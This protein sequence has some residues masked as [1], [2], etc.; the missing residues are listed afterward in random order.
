MENNFSE[1]AKRSNQEFNTAFHI[2]EDLMNKDCFNFWKA[3]DMNY[4]ERKEY[5][6]D[7]IFEY[8]H[9]GE[10]DLAGV[11]K[12]VDTTDYLYEG[13]A[14]PET[15]ENVNEFFKN[16]LLIAD[17]IFLMDEDMYEEFKKENS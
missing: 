10:I 11:I 8:F 13:M 9:C 1:I 16:E 17:V 2:I 7:M 5:L 14:S 6:R 15:I 4:E 12:H 3:K